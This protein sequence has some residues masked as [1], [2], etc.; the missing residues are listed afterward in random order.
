[1]REPL[2]SVII[3]VY[4]VEKYLDTCVHS[5]VSQTYSNLEIVLVDDG[6]TDSSSEK[7]DMWVAKDARIKVVH[8]ENQGLN[9]ARRDGLATSTG[10]WVSFVDSDDIIHQDAIADMLEA[11]LETRTDIVAARNQKF[12]N[13]EDITPKQKQQSEGTLIVK[14]KKELMRYVLVKSPDENVFMVITC[15]KLFRRTIIDSIDW[16]LSNSRANEDELEAIQYYTIQKRGVA[17]LK[18]TL[19]YYRNNPT[20]ITNKQY[21][22]TY[23]GKSFSRFEWIEELYKITTNFFGEKIYADEVLYHNIML[24]LLS[25]NKDITRGTFTDND[26]DMF[27]KYF[28]PKIES[29]KKIST[30]YPL[31]YEEKRALEQMGDSG[32]FMIWTADRQIIDKLRQDN[33]GLRQYNKKLNKEI[34]DIKKSRFYKLGVKYHKIT[35]KG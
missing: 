23:Q 1:M 4:N 17:V 30:K 6:S 9:Y 19:Y 35:R 7:C 8:K 14:N 5:V 12:V 24:N 21:T 25:F 27:R 33:D 20:S 2:V 3:P 34:E 11:A 16:N 15:S 26:Y 29:F 13:E 10:D 31:F 22:N 18:K 32:L 28:Y